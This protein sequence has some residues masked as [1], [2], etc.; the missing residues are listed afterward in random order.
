MDTKIKMIVLM[1]VLFISTS[2]AQESESVVLADDAEVLEVRTSSRLLIG[3]KKTDWVDEMRTKMIVAN[4]PT[5]PFGLTQDP[6]VKAVKPREQKVEK[7]AFL[8]AIGAIQI[9]TVMPSDNLFISNS[10][11]FSVGD[12]FPI[13][14]N[15]RQFDIEIVAISSRGIIFKNTATGEQVR[16]KLNTLPAGMKKSSHLGDIQG[17]YAANKKNAR[18]LNLDDESVSQIR[19]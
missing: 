9:N 7:G 12:Q 18:P 13:I 10:R 5:G 1:S 4:R 17:V 11:E 14:K 2:L 6:N 15:Q 16:K 8:E 3:Q 19:K